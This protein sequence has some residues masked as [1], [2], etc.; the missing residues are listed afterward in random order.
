M[1][2]FH[3]IAAFVLLLVLW[4]T[5]GV[6]VLDKIILDYG[7]VAG[8][9]TFIAI[10]ACVFYVA[11][12]AV[13]KGFKSVVLFLCGF[14]SA[15]VWSPPL[16]IESGLFVKEPTLLLISC[17][18]IAS[19]LMAYKFK[20]NFKDRKVVLPA[21]LVSGLVLAG[22]SL[23]YAEPESIYLT[24]NQALSSDVFFYTVFASLGAPHLIS[25]ILTYIFVPAASLYIFVENVSDFDGKFPESRLIQ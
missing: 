12:E 24:P 2:K 16:M 7:V 6:S 11:G 15:D 19:S 20:I 13:D 17:V 8:Y 23:G 5:A 22:M 14:I 18:L 10:Y 21:L 3:Y 1:T 25:W 9:L 4:Y